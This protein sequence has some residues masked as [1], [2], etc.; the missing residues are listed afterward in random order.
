MAGLPDLIFVHRGKAFGLE[1]ETRGRSLSGEQRAAQLAL[2]D[3]GMRVEVARDLDE[4]LMHLRDMGIPLKLRG[5][6]TS[7]AMRAA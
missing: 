5:E 1:L 7:R 4:A 2:R 3:A 6:D